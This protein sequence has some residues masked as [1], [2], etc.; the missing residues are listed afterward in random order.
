MRKIIFTFV[1]ILSALSCRAGGDDVT[2]TGR[3]S[4]LPDGTKITL[5]T[6]ATHTPINNIK[7]TAEAIVADGKF[8]L[9]FQL[10]EPR[11]FYVRAEGIR[12]LITLLLSPG[13]NVLLG[14]TFNDPV[15]SGAK[16]QDQWEEKFVKPRA[17]SNLKQREMSQRFAE[18]SKKM[19]TA[20]AANDREAI[21]EI[22]ASEEW[23]AYNQASKERMDEF[24][25]QLDEAVADNHDTFWG[26]MLVL[27]HTA[28][29]TQDLEKYYDMFSDE[30]KSSFY[31]QIFREQ[32]FGAT[33]KAP[34]FTAKDENG[35]E[36]TLKELLDGGHYVLIDFWASWCGPCRRF[37][38]TVKELAVKYKDKGLIV[39]SIST[40]TDHAAWVKAIEEE[41]M[42]WLNLIDESGISKIY[43]VTAIPSIFLVNPQGKILF[44]KQS[45]Q[46]VVDKL[47]EVFGK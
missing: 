45:G 20:R 24:Y 40:D 6:G 4:G 35:S 39:V 9:E 13:D 30:T 21:A 26:P 32:L 46:N 34:D 43:G 8:V 25:N 42:P 29:L 41:Q 36:H 1:L 28:Y 18:V 27:A 7:P 15:V 12:G 10:E 16:M 19:G 22:E 5:V 47:A 44:G 3:L 23:I 37:V 11:L 2:V 14:G 38:P 31:G 33:G 17:N